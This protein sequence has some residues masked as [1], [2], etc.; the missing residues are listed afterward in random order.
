MNLNLCRSVGTKRLTNSVRFVSV[1]HAEVE[2]RN[3]MIKNRIEKHEN[4]SLNIVETKLACDRIDS[5]QFIIHLISFY[6]RTIKI[7]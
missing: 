3:A 4:F 7:L 5:Q 1:I 6:R 2:Q